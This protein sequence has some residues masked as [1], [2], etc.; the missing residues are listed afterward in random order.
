[1]LFCFLHSFEI[2]AENETESDLKLPS[3]FWSE[4]KKNKKLLR[5]LIIKILKRL[6]KKCC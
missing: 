2:D 6:D 4:K 5:K 3:V 1:M